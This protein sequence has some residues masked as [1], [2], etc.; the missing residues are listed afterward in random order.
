MTTYNQTSHLMGSISLWVP[1]ARWQN[2]YL[3]A[4]WKWV[5]VRGQSNLC[6]DD[7]P[8]GRSY[9]GEHLSSGSCQVY[10]LR[11][12]DLQHS[13]PPH[14]NGLGGGNQE[15]W[16]WLDKWVPSHEGLYR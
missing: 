4:L 9:H 7:I 14:S 10:L 13:L 6:G 16:S 1:Q 12:Q 2:Q 11:R 5:R 15:K 3:R 8:K